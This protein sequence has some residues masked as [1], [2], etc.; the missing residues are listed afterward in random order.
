MKRVAGTLKLDLAQFSELAA[1]AQF[2]SSDLDAATKRRIER[3]QHQTEILKQPQY[4]PMSVEHQIMI[5][6]AAGNGYLDDVPVDKVAEWEDAFH[7]YMD[8]AHP[9]VG[10][11]IYDNGVVNVEKL[12]EEPLKERLKEL[13]EQL[14][15]A[16]IEFKKSAPR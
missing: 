9:E 6:W 7:R 13:F 1:F 15:A 10:K 2:G 5:I 4:Q 11:A 3:G 12:E 16:V 14:R 8:A